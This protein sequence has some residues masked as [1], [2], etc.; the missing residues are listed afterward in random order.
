VVKKKSIE[1]TEAMVKVGV[2][3]LH[4]NGISDYVGVSALEA[5]VREIF[6]LMS[7]A[8]SEDRSKTDSNRL[9]TL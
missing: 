1:V 6:M 5:M 3:V 2:T 8:L 9:L 7:E 4:E